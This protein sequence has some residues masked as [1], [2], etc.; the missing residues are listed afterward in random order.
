MKVYIEDIIDVMDWAASGGSY[1]NMETGAILTIND[2]L[3]SAC[4]KFERLPANAS[5]EEVYKTFGWG[6]EYPEF[7][8]FLRHEDQYKRLPDQYDI[9]EYRIMEDFIATVEDDER[10]ETLWAAIRGKGAFRRFIDTCY[11]YG[12]QKQWYEFKE[13]RLLKIAR[14]WC[15]DHGI[16]YT[17]RHPEKADA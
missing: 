4:R 10:R 12:I 3:E 9:H 15:A 17:Y 6:W 16:S 13:A 11:R 1:L 8:N 14:E 5:D 2:D 7:L